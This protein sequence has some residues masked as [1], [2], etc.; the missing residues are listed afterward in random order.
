MNKDWWEP[1]TLHLL[2]KLPSLGKCHLSV[3]LI[4]TPFLDHTLHFMSGHALGSPRVPRKPSQH[5][6]QTSYFKAWCFSNYFLIMIIFPVKWK[7]VEPGNHKAAWCSDMWKQIAICAADVDETHLQLNM[8]PDL[9]E[10]TECNIGGNSHSL[11]QWFS[12]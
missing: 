8:L 11:L 1:Q 12:K 4:C 5:Q 6:E 9:T 3:C 7:T 2:F 10:P